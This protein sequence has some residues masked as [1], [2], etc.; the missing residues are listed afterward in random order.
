MSI[1][2]VAIG[3]SWGGLEALGIL[4]ESLPADFAPPVVI[5]QHR[6]RGMGSELSALLQGK[7]TLLLVEVEDKMAIAP[8]RIHLAPSDY[9]LLVEA[10][11][12]SLSIDPPVNHA[13]PAIDLLLMTAAEA[14]GGRLVGV[15]LTGTGEDGARGLAAVTA[16]GGL[17]IV[18]DPASAAQ[19][20][21]PAAALRAAPHATVLPLAA[22]GPFLV[23]QCRGGG[24]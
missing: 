19:P 12:F 23:R 10:D 9:H 8:R 3:A 14:F 24:P 1:G 6:E 20:G 11:V 13:R 2:L 5:V 17:A 18:E 16:R 15:V 21:M 4:L 7:S 22:I